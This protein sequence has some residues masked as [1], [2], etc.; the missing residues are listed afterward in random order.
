MGTAAQ[1]KRNLTVLLQVRV[2]KRAAVLL[3]KRARTALRTQ[4]SYLRALLYRD[5]GLLE[6]GE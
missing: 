5:L 4:A 3:R 6:A 1:T 2:N